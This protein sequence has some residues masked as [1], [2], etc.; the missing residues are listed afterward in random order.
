[1]YRTLE[2]EIKKAEGLCL[3]ELPY[4]KAVEIIE[5]IVTMVLDQNL[6]PISFKDEDGGYF[7][8]LYP[9]RL[10]KEY[11]TYSPRINAGDSGFKRGC[12]Q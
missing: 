7:I 4:E 1:M 11:L 2:N 6:L 5:K 3:S 12:Q 8:H 9:K 10:K